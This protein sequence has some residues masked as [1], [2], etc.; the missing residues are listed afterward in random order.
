MGSATHYREGATQGRTRTFTG[1]YEF[2]V[3]YSVPTVR[4]G[5]EVLCVSVCSCACVLTCVSCM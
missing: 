5:K 1:K 2:D 4:V 3:L